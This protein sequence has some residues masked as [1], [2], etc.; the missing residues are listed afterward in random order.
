MH[1]INIEIKGKEILNPPDERI[2]IG[3]EP[4]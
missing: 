3:K 4:Q 2:A 1:I